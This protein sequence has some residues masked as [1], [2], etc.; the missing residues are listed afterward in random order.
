MFYSIEV[1]NFNLSLVNTC[2]TDALYMSWDI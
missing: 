2:V 1:D